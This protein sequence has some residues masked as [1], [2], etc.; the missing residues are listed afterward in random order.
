MKTEMQLPNIS[1]VVPHFEMRESLHDLIL[2]LDKVDYPRSLV[3]VIVVDN[4]SSEMPRLPNSEIRVKILREPKPGSYAARNTA[5]KAASGRAIAFTDADCLPKS[6][7]LMAGVTG[8]LKGADRVAGS[9]EVV[10]DPSIGS[11][12]YL[13][14]EAFS[15]DV[16][17]DLN[18]KAHVATANMFTW[19]SLFAEVGPFDESAFSGGDKEWSQRFFQCGFN[20][21]FCPEATVLH[22]ARSFTEL[23]HHRRRLAGSV[24]ST[25]V[26]GI[27]NLVF[28]RE[29]FRDRTQAIWRVLRSSE[30]FSTKVLA[31]VVALVLYSVQFFWSAWFVAFPNQIPPRS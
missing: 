26:R 24:L 18:T 31:L 23:V 30:S 10:R 22:R 9:I 1:V 12:T 7:W 28:K 11:G 16:E 3:E 6:D 13:Y 15:F 17:A 21:V 29:F 8:L 2:A 25:N 27:Q 5:L 4:G 20:T 19:K 14:Q